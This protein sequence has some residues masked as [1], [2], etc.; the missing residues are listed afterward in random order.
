M[1]NEDDRQE[2]G[3]PDTAELLKRAKNGDEA[4]FSELVQR[5]EPLMKG[6]V[7]RY[8]MGFEPDDLHQEVM[9]ALYSAVGSYELGRDV[10][11]G[12]YARICMRNRILNI[13]RK[14]KRENQIEKTVLPD[15]EADPVRGLI[16]EESCRMLL[17]SDSY[18]LTELEKRVLRLYLAD[19][20]YEQIAA[21]L[22]ITEKSVDNAIYR[23]KAKLR[24]HM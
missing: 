5:Y 10:T 8:G 23:V 19:M 7:R 24:K 17:G 15:E 13:M 3:M 21:S 14:H 6:M 1:I 2:A 4:A 20:S 18:G 9:L 12:A 11:F 16:S 22:Q